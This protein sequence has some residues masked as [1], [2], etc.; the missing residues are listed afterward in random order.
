MLKTTFQHMNEDHFLNIDIMFHYATAKNVVVNVWDSIN[1]L[2]LS[3]SM[4]T[5]FRFN[6][7]SDE[8]MNFKRFLCY[9]YYTYLNL[10]TRYLFQESQKRR[11]K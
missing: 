9:L 3:S 4:K 5:S 7:K 2:Y 10:P 8:E 6:Y 11:E 1:S